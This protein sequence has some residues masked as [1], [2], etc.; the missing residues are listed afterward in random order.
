M[1]KK[2]GIDQRYVPARQT[3][4]PYH[5]GQVPGLILATSPPI[6]HG[7]MTS[8]PPLSGRLRL[9]L[10]LCHETPRTSPCA[11][12]TSRPPIMSIGRRT[13]SNVVKSKRL[14]PGYQC[15]R[16]QPD[17]RSPQRWGQ[18]SPSHITC[19]NYV[20]KGLNDPRI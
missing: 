7:L 10:S 18:Q 1:N 6:R 13:R 2:Y 20:K 9:G 17:R 3:P 11:P 12:G 5:C 15:Q 16:K 19:F 8:L 4:R 14:H